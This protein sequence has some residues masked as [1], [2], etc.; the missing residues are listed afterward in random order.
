[1][2]L[3][4]QFIQDKIHKKAKEEVSQIANKIVNKTSWSHILLI[5]TN[6]IEK[7]SSIILNKSKIKRADIISLVHQSVKFNLNKLI[8]TVEQTNPC[9]LQ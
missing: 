5:N 8:K 9:D 7:I 1:M 3:P 2:I 4:F 6:R